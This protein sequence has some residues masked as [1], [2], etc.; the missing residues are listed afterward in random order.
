M[1]GENASIA[2]SCPVA[3]TESSPC[4]NPVTSS[5]LTFDSQGNLWAAGASQAAGIDL[6][7][8]CCLILLPPYSEGSVLEF[9]STPVPEFPGSAPF[10]GG[11]QDAEDRQRYSNGVER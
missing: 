6:T 3:S 10:L 1:N 8:P 2:I 11:R 9:T 7:Q 5:G 4:G